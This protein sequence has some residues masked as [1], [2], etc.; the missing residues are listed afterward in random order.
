MSATL[1]PPIHRRRFATTD[2]DQ[3]RSWFENNLITFRPRDASR[4]VKD[5]SC[6]AQMLTA[7]EF[8]LVHA[9]CSPLPRINVEPPDQLL[10]MTAQSPQTRFELG[11]SRR[12]ITPGFHQPALLPPRTS[13]YARSGP[14]DIGTVVLNWQIVLG[15]AA[16][17]TGLPKTGLA[18]D[19]ARPVPPGL[20]R[21]WLA[22]VDYVRDTVLGNATAV[23]NPIILAEAAR[24]LATTVLATFTH[25]GLGDDTRT[26]PGTGR[27]PSTPAAIRRA[28]CFIET[29]AQSPITMTDIADAAR[30]GPRALHYAFRRHQDTT[31]MAYLRQVRLDHAHHDLRKADP[32]RGDTVAG[33]AAR[34]G[35]PHAARFAA[36]YRETYGV[37]PATSLRN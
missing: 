26:E 10:V 4:A 36:A 22:T 16:E 30:I 33:I 21:H 29:H 27:D 3:F 17:T 24:L 28:I 1:S 13:N 18:F 32:A 7:G 5:F 12:S 34:W 6:S 20:S 35:F 9:R 37:T 23:G 2:F 8:S 25:S 11:T 14:L 15:M 19:W 31:P